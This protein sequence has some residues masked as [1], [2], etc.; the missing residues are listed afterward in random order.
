M[1]EFRLTGFALLLLAAAPALAQTGGLP[2]TGP[3]IGLTPDHKRTIYREISEEPIR[4]LA[5]SE[6]VAI[7]AEIPDRVMLNEMPVSVKDKVGVLRD[8][9]FAKLSNGTIVIVDPARRKIVDIVTED[10]G[11][12]AP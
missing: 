6:Q 2:P 8:F 4:P 7:G 9:K 5:E 1:P 10:E 12:A 11:A 3:G